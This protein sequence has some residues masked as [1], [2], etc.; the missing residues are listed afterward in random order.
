M[1]HTETRP[2][3]W[4]VPRSDSGER[5]HELAHVSRTALRTS[6]VDSSDCQYL[7]IYIHIKH[8]VCIIGFD[9]SADCK[10]WNHAD[11]TVHH[12]LHCW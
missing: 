9:E 10:W 8:T 4:V 2:S 6:R 5:L 7:L 12:R 11:Y 3:E 1:C